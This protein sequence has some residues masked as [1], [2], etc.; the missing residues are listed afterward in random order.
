MT[1]VERHV[2]KMLAA[3]AEEQMKTARQASRAESSRREGEEALRALG[4]LDVDSDSELEDDDAAGFTGRAR[5]NL[6]RERKRADGDPFL[7]DVVVRAMTSAELGMAY[8]WMRR[9]QHR[10]E[11]AVKFWDTAASSIQ[12]A[13]EDNDPPGAKEMR[14]ALLESDDEWIVSSTASRVFG[15][16][17][18]TLG[19]APVGF[20]VLRDDGLVVDAM[21]VR[22]GLRH[23]GFGKVLVEALLNRA[24]IAAAA[25]AG[26][27][28]YIV[29][30][31]PS[32]VPFWRSLGFLPAGGSDSPTTKVMRRLC[33]DVAMAFELL[34]DPPAPNGNEWWLETRNKRFGNAGAGAEKETR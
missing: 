3:H 21:G 7:E 33:G 32:S 8:A 29:D 9:D 10:Y 22:Q 23:F 14:D 5:R 26:P 13:F 20:A 15:V 16:F 6:R 24:R 18:S 4:D 27:P 1:V 11:N 2:Q 34:E 30:A 12:A 25:R 28:E 31:L 19:P 17:C